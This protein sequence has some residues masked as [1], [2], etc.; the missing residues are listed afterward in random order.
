MIGKKTILG[1][2]ALL[3]L[4]ALVFAGAISASS[5]DDG[6][7][8]GPNQLVGSWE[9]NVDRSPLPPIKSMFTYI[10]DGTLV[11]TGSLATRGPSHGAWEQLKNRQ[12]AVTH[13]FFRFDPTGTYLGTQKINETLDLAKDGESYT[14]VAISYLYDTSGNLVVGGLRATITATRIHV[15]RNPGP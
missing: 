3:A 9:L 12:Y 5:A 1:V 14:S 7:G 10:S 2:I 11:E 6:N 4:T 13:I 15:E 8:Q